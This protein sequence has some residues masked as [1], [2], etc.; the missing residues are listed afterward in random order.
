MR[1]NAIACW[2]V[3]VCLAVGVG[4]QAQSQRKSSAPFELLANLA[5]KRVTESSGLAASLKTPG[6]IWTHNDTGDGPYLY[7]TDRKGRALARFR[8]VGARNVDWEDLAAGPGPDGA[9]SLYI[10]DFGDNGENRRDCCIYIVPD[11][12]VDLRATGQE[13]ETA[14]ARRYPFRY[15]DGP[16]DAE[17]LL[18]HPVT[19]EVLIVTKADSGRS[20]V[21][22]MPSPLVRDTDVM[23]RRVGEVE[24]ANPMVFGRRAV[25]KLATG[26]AVAPDGRHVAI[27]TYTDVFEWSVGAGQTL[28]DALAGARRKIAAPWLGQF[29]S[30]SYTPDGKFLLTT[31]EGSP[32]TLWQAQR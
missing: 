21:Y 12:E 28:A 4:A 14:L 25:W 8:V 27:R 10:G 30:L 3:C 13:R 5:E 2:I 32:C 16:H 26:G 29:E 15:P 20:G 18:V 6:V 11:P 22:R 17:T 24:F 7:A 31:S 19:G 9:P 1:R 23:L